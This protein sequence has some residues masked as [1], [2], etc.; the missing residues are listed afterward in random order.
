M[1]DRKTERD[2]HKGKERQREICTKEKKDRERT[3]EREREQET[4]RGSIRQRA[5]AAGLP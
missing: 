4:E 5:S 1:R 2:P 3:R